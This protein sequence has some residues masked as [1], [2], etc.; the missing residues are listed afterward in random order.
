MASDQKDISSKQSSL[1][2]SRKMSEEDHLVEDNKSRG[3]AVMQQKSP[4]VQ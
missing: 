1:E 4:S 3:E 2:K